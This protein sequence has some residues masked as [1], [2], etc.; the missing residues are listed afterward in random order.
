[1][2]IGDILNDVSMFEKAKYRI[3]MGNPSKKSR[4]YYLL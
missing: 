2:V 1:M 4:I 3:A